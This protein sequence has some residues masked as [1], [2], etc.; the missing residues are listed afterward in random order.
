MIPETIHYLWL[1]GSKKPRYVQRCMD[2]WKTFLGNCAVREWT[3]EDLEKE[4]L[5]DF[6]KGSFSHYEGYVK[7]YILYRYGGIMLDPGTVMLSGIGDLTPVGCYAFFLND[8]ASKKENGN[9]N[10]Y[11]RAL[12]DDFVPGMGIN[13]SFIASERNHPFLKSYMEYIERNWKSVR[14]ASAAD[15]LAFSARR[16]GFLYND[17]MQV[18]SLGML[19]YPSGFFAVD[20]SRLDPNAKAVYAGGG[21]GLAAIRNRKTAL[22]LLRDAEKKSDL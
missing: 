1:S 15:T 8:E 22:S 13:P 12:T 6:V 11:G 9:L 18:L 20:P 10:Y 2:S 19:I 16:F 17:E 21:K 7:A 14:R 4:E 5:P 3:V